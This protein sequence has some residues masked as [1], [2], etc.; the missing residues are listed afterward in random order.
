L[1]QIMFN[2]KQIC[3]F[4]FVDYSN[5]PDNQSFHGKAVAIDVM[6][7]DPQIFI[8]P[9]HLSRQPLHHQ[10]L[11][12]RHVHRHQFNPACHHEHRHHPM[13]PNTRDNSRMPGKKAT[14]QS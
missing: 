5:N 6:I 14:T 11:L 4:V 7:L 1:G 13:R 10:H 9:Q 2:K 12:S 3:K 8:F